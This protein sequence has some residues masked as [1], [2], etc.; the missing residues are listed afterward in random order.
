[1]EQLV[2]INIFYD[3]D[4]ADVFK[5]KENKL[6]DQPVRIIFVS[7]IFLGPTITERNKPKKR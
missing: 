3:S 6:Q 2:L 4:Q 1:M 5:E 7:L